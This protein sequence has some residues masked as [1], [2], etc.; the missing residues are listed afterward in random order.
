MVFDFRTFADARIIHLRTA[1]HYD[2]PISSICRATSVSKKAIRLRSVIDKI[3]PRVSKNALVSGG[4]YFYF[5]TIDRGRASATGNTAVTV[6]AS[7]GLVS[8][9]PVPGPRIPPSRER[10]RCACVPP[11]WS[12]NSQGQGLGSRA[13]RRSAAC[14]P[15][16]P[17][18]VCV[19]SRE[20]ASQPLA[21]TFFGR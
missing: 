12:R 9:A 21:R 6:G 13:V 16:G 5:R 15:C 4:I 10:S 8:D 7:G 17:F 11:S 14:V 20:I 2:L 1:N 18:G 19:R 3:S